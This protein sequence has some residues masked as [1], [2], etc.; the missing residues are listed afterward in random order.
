MRT[1]IAAFAAAAFTIGSLT[2]AV[3]AQAAQNPY[4][5]AVPTN[6]AKPPTVQMLDCNGTTGDHGCG[7]GFHWRNGNHGWACY[8][9]D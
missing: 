7:A 2:T 9:C 5:P 6:P 8:P 4:D 1:R 3:H